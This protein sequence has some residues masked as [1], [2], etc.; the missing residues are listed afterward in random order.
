MRRLIGPPLGLLLTIATATA[1]PH[2][3]AQAPVLCPTPYTF[4]NN[5]EYVATSVNNHDYLFKFY[6]TYGW[7]SSGIAGAGRYDFGTIT[8][9]DN[10]AVIYGAYMLATCNEF[11]VVTPPYANPQR[12]I[13]VAE[14]DWGYSSFFLKFTPPSDD[15]EDC[16]WDEMRVQ[17]KRPDTQADARRNTVNCT[18]TGGSGGGDPTLT[19]YCLYYDYYTGDGVYMYSVLQYCWVQ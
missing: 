11:Y 12:T 5:A 14:T 4:N 16:Y 6:L 9:V 8:S 1:P 17:P 7:T 18:G 15:S 10:K 13:V 2:L 19:Q 3:F